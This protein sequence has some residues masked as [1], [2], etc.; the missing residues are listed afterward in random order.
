MRRKIF[1]VL[2]AIFFMATSIALLAQIKEPVEPV[3]W[4][5][6]TP[7]LIDIPEWEAE[8]DAEGSSMDMA[9]FKISQAERSYTAEE[10]NLTITIIDGGYVPIV[11]AGIKMAMG[12]ELDTAEE[13]VKKVTI[14]GFPGVE[15][16]ENE[17][18]KAEVMILVIDR[19]LIQL[20]GQNFENAS[21]LTEIAQLLDLE[22]ISNLAQ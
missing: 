21:T 19:F 13:Y 18:K 6:L 14:K 8:G 2:L 9:G 7:F 10:K 17:D 20:E 16:Y 11:Y 5:E 1:F 15:K 3:N 22:G 12:F 4:R